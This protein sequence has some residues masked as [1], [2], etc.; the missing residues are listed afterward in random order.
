VQDITVYHMDGKGLVKALFIE[1]DRTTTHRNR[2][3]NHSAT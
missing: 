1:K 3:K 2:R